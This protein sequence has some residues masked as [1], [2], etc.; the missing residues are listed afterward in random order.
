MSQSHLILSRRAADLTASPIRDIL[1]VIDRPGMVSFAGGLPSSDSFPDLDRLRVPAGQLQYG[2]T[3][4]EPGLR[5][6]VAAG[7]RS[8]GLDCGADQV[9]ILSGSQQGIDLVAKL[10]IDPQTPVAVESPTYLAALQVFRFF[11]ARLGAF[12]IANAG[13]L[14]AAIKDRA[15][16]YAIPNFQNPTGK[17]YSEA[18]RARLAS[19]C[20][21]TLTPLYED[22]PYRD[23]A[24]DNRDTSAVCSRLKRAPWIYQG[25]FSKSLAPGLRLGYLACS[26]GLVPYLTRL[27]QAADLHS[28]RVSQWFV[29]QQLNEPT[30]DARLASLRVRYRAKRDQFDAELE[31]H[32]SELASWTSPAGGLFFWLALNTTR[33]IDTRRLLPAAIEQGVAFMPGE[34]FFPGPVAAASALR[35]NFSYAAAA[36]T[37]RGLATLARIFREALGNL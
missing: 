18:E 24:Y 35:L 12:A 33:P 31:R 25:S 8:R 23:L 5:S 4:G 15:F 10:F 28:N 2:P 14:D 19:A 9:L 22:D 36:E 29:L 17:C 26:P 21:R 16:V 37:R 6:K 11:G 13:D 1:A 34:P 30:H 3:E 7:L 20:D 27:K 32:F